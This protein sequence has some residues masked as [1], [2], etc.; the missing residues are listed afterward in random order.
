MSRSPS[1]AARL[2][3]CADPAMAKPDDPIT[4]QIP[5][6]L[7]PAEPPVIARRVAGLQLDMEEFPRHGR[8]RLLYRV[9]RHTFSSLATAAG[10][11][12]LASSSRACLR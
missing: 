6:R 7:D 1:P 5:P 8:F 2:A 3:A 10:L 12:P 11:S 4:E 9:A